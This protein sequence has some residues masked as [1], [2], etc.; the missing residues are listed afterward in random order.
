MPVEVGIS[1]A[2]YSKQTID[3]AT[4]LVYNTPV[5]LPGL[6]SVIINPNIVESVLYADNGPAETHT[7]I[8]K[9]DVEIETADLTL[10]EQ[11]DLLG[12]TFANGGIIRK[13]S[14]VAPYIAFGFQTLKTNGK[15]RFVWLKKGKFSVPSAE[16]RTQG[17]QIQYNTSK[18]KA[19]F[20]MTVYDNA[21]EA[22]IDEDESTYVPA[23]GTA[24]FT[25][26]TLAVGLAATAAPT[27]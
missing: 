21:W 24:W 19:S 3:N 9:I 11:A 10:K 12:H 26:T 27:P 5:A 14:D 13:A 6:I 15:S 4:A 1:N 17:E 18:I 2:H 20:V 25:D 22:R 16:H 8:S 23:N 7:A